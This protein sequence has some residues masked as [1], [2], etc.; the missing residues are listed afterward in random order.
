M[1]SQRTLSPQTTDILRMIAGGHNYEQILKARPDLSYMDIFAAAK[2]ALEA[3]KAATP[4]CTLPSGEV[5]AP[6]TEDAGRTLSLSKL[7]ER[8]P[9]A[10][11]KWSP[12][13]EED[14]LDLYK[15]GLR[16][17]EI[18]EQI[19]RQPSAVRTHLEKLIAALQHNPNP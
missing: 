17:R 5:A 19:G 6:N 11:E 8:Y 10:Y 9:R 15:K 2:E 13:E 12:E 14:L 4:S 3:S 1:V 18:G 16:P 7:R